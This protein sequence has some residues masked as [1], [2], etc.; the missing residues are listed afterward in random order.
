MLNILEKEKQEG[1]ISV[2]VYEKMKR[3]IENRKE[4]IEKKI[5]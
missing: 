1:I 5:K 3:S 2:S 4:K